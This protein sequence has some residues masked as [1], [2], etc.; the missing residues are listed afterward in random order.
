MNDEVGVA[1]DRAGE[2]A[3]VLFRES[4]VTEGID[5]IRGTLEAFE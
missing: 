4:V 1:T 5:I 3:V 2:V